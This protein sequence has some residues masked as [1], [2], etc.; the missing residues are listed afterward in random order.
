[1][2]PTYIMDKSDQLREPL[3]QKI[4]HFC[5]YLNLKK[6]LPQKETFQSHRDNKEFCLVFL[7]DEGCTREEI[8][9][10]NTFQHNL[11]LIYVMPSV[12][13]LKKTI[14]WQAVAYLTLPFQDVQFAQAVEVARIEL[15]KK[16]AELQ[17]DIFI[18]Q[19]RFQLPENRLVGIPTIHGQEILLADDI[20]RCEGLQ[21]CT[22]IVS[23]TKKD[24]ISAHPIG[25]FKKALKKFP[26]FF[27]THRS[28]Y[29]NLSFVDRYLKSGIICMKDGAEVPIVKDQ[30]QQFLKRIN[31]V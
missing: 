27:S 22:R 18:N 8:S 1:M 25:Y 29:I 6:T 24:L 15:L 13:I 28:H 10:I 2:I 20:V 12:S 11:V 3:V 9:T 30:R 4:S 19:F 17:R 14:Q 16:E 26:Y 23:I 7:N 21:R 31:S 5:P